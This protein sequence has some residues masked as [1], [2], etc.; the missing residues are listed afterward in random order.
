MSDPS[1][2]HPLTRG[3]AQILV[4]LFAENITMQTRPAGGH[5]HV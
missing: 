3:I 5:P 2:R 1:I 4:R